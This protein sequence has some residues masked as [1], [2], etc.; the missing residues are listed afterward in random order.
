MKFNLTSSKG[1]RDWLADIKARI[2]KAQL[3]A[4]VTVNTQLLKFYWELGAEIVAKQ[5]HSE[6]GDGFLPQLSKDLA[7]EFPGMTGF[8]QSNLKYIKQWYLFYSQG[9]PIGQQPVGQIAQQL[10]AKIT[11]IP[12]GHNIA[13]I[14]K[15][16]NIDEALYYVRGVI[17]HN[18]SRSVLVHQIESGLH[19]RGGKAVSNFA[20]TLPKPQ[21][22]LAVQTLKDPYIF[23]FL[24]MTADYKER[25]LESALVEHVTQFLLELGAGFAYVGRQVPLKAGD[26]EFFIDLLFYHTKLRCY[27]VVELK[28]ADFEPEHAG[29]MNFYLKA[30]DARFR[31]PH[32]NP[33]VGILICK[34]KDKVVVE[35]ALSDIRKPI[36]VSEYQLT[37]ALPKKFKSSL[38]EITT[39]Q[40]ELGGG[41]K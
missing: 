6:W 15:C 19:R 38:P 22:D 41:R 24:S 26:R 17:E 37:Q 39:I 40:A 23:D 7:A 36:G 20:V 31:T 3:K 11:S 35:Y 4:I 9:K 27:V 28:T 14:S 5:T 12:W 33:T 2:R 13:I 29:K 18:W 25:E 34:S 21:S 8:S 30:V 16:G 10:V 1:Y 32:D